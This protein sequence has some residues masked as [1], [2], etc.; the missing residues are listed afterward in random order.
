MEFSLRG[1]DLTL[2]LRYTESVCIKLNGT[3]LRAQSR[4]RGLDTL[5]VFNVKSDEP[6]DD[7]F[8]VTLVGPV[9]YFKGSTGMIRVTVEESTITLT[10]SIVDV[11][12]PITRDVVSDFDIPDF[13][14]DDSKVVPKDTRFSL[15]SMLMTMA[16]VS[17]ELADYSGNRV[18]IK[19]GM[20]TYIN[21]SM[22]L[23]CLADLPDMCV[24]STSLSNLLALTNNA[25]ELGVYD[26]GDYVIFFTED[27]VVRLL[28]DKEVETVTAASLMNAGKGVIETT[29]IQCVGQAKRFSGLSSFRDSHTASLT[30]N[31]SAIGISMRGNGYSI[32]SSVKGVTI[33]VNPRVLI[34]L[35]KFLASDEYTIERG[36]KHIC[37]SIPNRKLVICAT[38]Y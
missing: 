11:V 3:Y 1:E 35:G 8:A 31:E 16:D 19:D 20:A 7:F 13:N 18:N 9:S 21:H 29:H 10:D 12:L 34:V 4:L 30:Y 37:L 14:T 22:L 15:R 33:I 2:L 26:A 36:A 17:K 27:I 24:S 38:S 25:N 32:F 23:E 5:M 28:K 6:M